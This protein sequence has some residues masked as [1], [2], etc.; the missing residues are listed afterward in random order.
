M[1]AKRTAI[2]N[3]G[4]GKQHGAVLMIMLVIMIVGIAAILVNSLSSSTVKTA[5]QENTAA[6]LAQ[7][8]DALIGDTISLPSVTSAGYLRLP[9]L[10]F[11]IGNV[12]AEG[13]SAPNFSGNATDYPVIGKVPWK[14]LGISPMRDAQ[15]ECPWYVVSGRFKKGS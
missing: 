2:F 14:T 3:Q 7:A 12:P 1:S 8:K 6:A 10:G 4:H 11:G 15:G 13:S 9:D 5:R